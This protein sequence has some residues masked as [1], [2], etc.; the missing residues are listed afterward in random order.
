[1]KE[2]KF[3]CNECHKEFNT[4]HLTLH[5]RIYSEEK[6]FICNYKECNQKFS[7][8]SNLSQHMKRHLA[9]K[10]HKCYNEC[11]QSFVIRNDLKRHIPCIHTNEEFCN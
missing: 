4:K 9:L 2:K 5:S 6:P 1:L 3:I 8:K 7:D 10:R 11:D